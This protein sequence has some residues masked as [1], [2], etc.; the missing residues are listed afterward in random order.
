MRTKPIVRII[1]AF[2]TKMEKRFMD[3]LGCV[4]YRDMKVLSAE[5]NE[6]YPV[7]NALQS[8]PFD[9]LDP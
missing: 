3:E 5:E 6:F 4:P 2:L 8:N 7:R 1:G 9:P